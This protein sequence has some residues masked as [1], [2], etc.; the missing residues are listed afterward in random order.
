MADGI[1][2]NFDSTALDESLTKLQRYYWDRIAARIYS[3]I[4]RLINQGRN[5]EGAKFLSY[6]PKYKA[7][8]IKNGYSGEVNLQVTS[9]MVLSINFRV[10]NGGFEIFLN[11]EAN[12]LK[13]R[14]IHRKKNWQVLIWGK[15]L[16]KEL[17][18][19][20]NE[21]FRDAGFL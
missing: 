15:A 6:D 14:E 3:K 11:G 9:Q 17:Y 1:T 12:N 21:A 8:K 10:Y 20:I 7:W 2:F 16:R 13:M 18:S 4:K 19:A 5:A